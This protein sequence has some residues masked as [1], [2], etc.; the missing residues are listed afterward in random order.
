GAAGLANR[1]VPAARLAAETRAL[2]EIVAA[3]LPVA[4]RIGKGAFYAQLE[5]PVDAAY[6][7]TRDAMVANL[8]EPDTAE[9]IQAFLEKRAP[10]WT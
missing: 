2:A 8:S 1:A 6:A 3:K 7:L 5:R 9:G 4:Q 10:R